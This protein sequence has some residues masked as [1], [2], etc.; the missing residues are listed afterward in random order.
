M[1]TR[2]GASNILPPMKVCYKSQVEEAVSLFLRETK[3][4]ADEMV[5]NHQDA[6]LTVASALLMGTK[7]GREIL[8]MLF[9]GVEI[10][11]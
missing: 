10:K 2:W 11:G 7:F 1:V 3:A 5:N 4:S 8:T 6:I 9:K